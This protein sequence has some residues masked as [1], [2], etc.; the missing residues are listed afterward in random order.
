MQLI[1]TLPVTCWDW[2][3]LLL[4]APHVTSHP[5]ALFSS[6]A[7]NRGLVLTAASAAG[8]EPPLGAFS[9]H[10]PGGGLGRVPVPLGPSL[11]ADTMSPSSTGSTS[12]GLSSPA[13][14]LLL[15]LLPVLPSPLLLLGSR[16]MGLLL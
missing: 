10:V 4:L 8:A 16:P 5:E 14:A 13:R 12:A 11:P 15:P 1:C 6:T 2:A 7:N 3:M 9:P